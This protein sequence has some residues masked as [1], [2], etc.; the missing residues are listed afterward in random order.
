LWTEVLLAMMHHIWWQPLLNLHFNLL[1]IFV[2]YRQHFAVNSNLR[3]VMEG[4]GHNSD[5]DMHLICLSINRK[6]NK[7]QSKLYQF[8][9]LRYKL[10]DIAAAVASLKST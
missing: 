1:I 10:N 8:G 4:M 3:K 2:K 9:S 5:D 6:I 7:W